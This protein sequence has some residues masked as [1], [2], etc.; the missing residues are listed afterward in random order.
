MRELLTAVAGHLAEQRDLWVIRDWLFLYGLKKTD[1][2]R[3]LSLT[4]TSRKSLVKMKR[5]G[6]FLLV[7]DSEDEDGRMPGLNGRELELG[8][9]CCSISLPAT[10]AET[11]GPVG[12]KQ[13]PT[14]LLCPCRDGGSGTEDAE[15]LGA[16]LG[17]GTGGGRRCSGSLCGCGWHRPV[18]ASAPPEALPSCPWFSFLLL[19]FVSLPASLGLLP[20]PSLFPEVTL[21]V[22]PPVSPL[23]SASLRHQPVAAP[24]HLG[25]PWK[26]LRL[27]SGGV[28]RWGEQNSCLCFL[29][30]AGRALQVTMAIR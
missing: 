5:W 9:G 26:T 11:R 1:R 28:L 23:P 12:Q 22:Q 25:V 17:A 3:V 15:G 16:Q 2:K 20:S 18:G 7:G 14:Q 30:P 29:A 19:G 4:G 8:A 13:G 21:V 27:P 6:G 10:R 24:E